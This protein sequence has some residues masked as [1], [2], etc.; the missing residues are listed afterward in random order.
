V[1]RARQQLLTRAGLAGDEDRGVRVGKQTGGPV[2]YGPQRRALA[3]DLAERMGLR[4]ERGEARTA[5]RCPVSRD[6]GADRLAK[7]VAVSREHHVIADAHDNEADGQAV[8]G[9]RADHHDRDV[10]W[11]RALGEHVGGLGLTTTGRH[12]QQGRAVRR[13]RRRRPISDHGP[14][15]RGQQGPHLAER[16]AQPENGDSDVISHPPRTPGRGP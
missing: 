10:G 16:V 11:R 5:G 9:V 14:C 3:D 7:G 6:G 1:E 15:L 8:G 2:E 12:D 4:F 13:G